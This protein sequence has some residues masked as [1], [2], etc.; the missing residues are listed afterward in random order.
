MKVNASA[1]AATYTAW[2]DNFQSTFES[3]PCLRTVTE[4]SGTCVLAAVSSEHY[5]SPLN[6]SKRHKQRHTCF[7]MWQQ[8]TVYVRPP[9][10]GIPGPK[11]FHIHSKHL[12]PVKLSAKAGGAAADAAPA[13]RRQAPHHN[14]P[15]QRGTGRLSGVTAMGQESAVAWA[16]GLRDTAAS[17]SSLCVGTPLAHTITHTHK[18]TRASAHAAWR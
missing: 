16:K 12:T 14:A 18:N 13:G 11:A 15:S 6:R 5:L 3:S 2:L 4:Q 17:L 1:C 8:R 10:N 7:R 9:L